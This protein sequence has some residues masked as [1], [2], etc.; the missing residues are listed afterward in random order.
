MASA[1]TRS[2]VFV[3]CAVSF[4]LV[5]CI[6]PESKIN[7]SVW[8]DTDQSIKIVSS[9]G[10]IGKSITLLPK[11]YYVGWAPIYYLPSDASFRITNPGSSDIQEA[12]RVAP[13]HVT[14]G[15][16][17]SDPVE[18]IRSAEST[19]LGECECSGVR[20]RVCEDCIALEIEKAIW[21]AYELGKKDK[22]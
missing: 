8:N 12:R 4:F 13:A 3:S 6:L 15:D 20:G 7:F 21:T 16:Q 11:Q 1:L 19:I 17:C 18:I 2:F 9:A 10:E 22:K 5:S 14:F